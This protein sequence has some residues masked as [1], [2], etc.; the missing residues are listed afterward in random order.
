[1]AICLIGH[2]GVTTAKKLMGL[3]FKAEPDTAKISG[4][5]KKEMLHVT[6]LNL[7][8]SFKTVLKVSNCTFNN[9]T[10]E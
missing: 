5:M 4:H 7:W 6:Q 8:R 1:M 3:G 10:Y 2:L 9:D